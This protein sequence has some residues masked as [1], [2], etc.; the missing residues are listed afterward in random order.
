MLKK[1]YSVSLLLMLMMMLVSACSRSVLGP[2]IPTATG[3]GTSPFPPAT[4]NSIESVQLFATQTALV[5]TLLAGGGNR[6]TTT[7]A[8]STSTPPGTG[9]PFSGQVSPTFFV[10][11][12]TPTGNTIVPVIGTSTP[13]RPSQYTI[14]PGEY[15]FCIAR[16]FNV[17]PNELLALNPHAGSESNLP[18]GLVLTIPQTGNPFPGD[19]SLHD[20]PTTYTIPESMTVYSLACYF[21]DIDPSAI[22]LANNLAVP[23]TVNAGQTMNI[24]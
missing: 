16:R 15:P 4:I 8:I 19:R 12:I 6:G 7:T 23:F 13:G 24:P 9:T 1:T 21:G 22:I 20:H 10:P 11:S 5:G 3:A 18:T 14:M 17:D 2:S